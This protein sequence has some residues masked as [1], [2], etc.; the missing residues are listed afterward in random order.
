MEVWNDVK[1][2]ALSPAQE[3][4]SMRLRVLQ[5]HKTGRNTMRGNNKN[6]NSFGIDMII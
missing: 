3:H 5:M 2:L 6:C 1:G 4:V